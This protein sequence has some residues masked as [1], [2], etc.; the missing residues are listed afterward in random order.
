MIS[1]KLWCYNRARE[2]NFSWEESE[3][4]IEMNL[5]VNQLRID[6]DGERTFQTE[7][8]YQRI[9][10]KSRKVNSQKEVEKTA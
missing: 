8:G 3:K 2:S 4:K 6:E 9:K 7:Q 1:G 5:K 10:Y